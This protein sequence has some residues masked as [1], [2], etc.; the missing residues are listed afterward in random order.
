MDFSNGYAIFIDDKYYSSSSKAV[1][2]GEEFSDED[3]IIDINMKFNKGTH[4]I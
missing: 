3:G 4:L 2:W 1:W